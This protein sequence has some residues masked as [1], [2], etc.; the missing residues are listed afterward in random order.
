LS[1]WVTTSP[2]RIPL[3]LG[4]QQRLV[5]GAI[6][7]LMAYAW[8]GD[9]RALE[10]LIE[11]AMVPHKEEALQLDD[12]SMLPPPRGSEAMPDA[13]HEDLDV[14]AVMARHIRRVLEMTGGTIHGPGG[15]GEPLGVDPNTLRSRMR[16]LG[17]PFGRHARAR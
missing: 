6:D 17:I 10:N 1:C 16:K 4:E 5:P 11:R 7:D 3:D 15:A 9:A 2:D 14:D 8:P 13:D 12:L